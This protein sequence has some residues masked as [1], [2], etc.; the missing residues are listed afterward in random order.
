MGV[1]FR[2]PQPSKMIVTDASL[3]LWDTH[4]DELTAQGMWSLTERRMY[5]N[6]LEHRAVEKACESSFHLISEQSVQIMT[7][8]VT[9]MFYINKQG[10][11][12]SSLFFQQA[13]RIG[14]WCISH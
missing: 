12:R 11:T 6:L 10:G 2:V 13:V 8:N 7:D 3:Q 5:I 14:N 4:V 9:T 1:L